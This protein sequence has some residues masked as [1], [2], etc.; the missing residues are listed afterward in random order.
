MS[1]DLNVIDD[2]VLEST[3]ETAVENISDDMNPADVASTIV[4]GATGTPIKYAPQLPPVKGHYDLYCLVLRWLDNPGPPISNASGATHQAAAIYK[5]LSSGQLIYNVI[6]KEVKVNL[7]HNA[8]NLNAAEHA[9]KAV[10][11]NPTGPHLYA[12]FN[13]HVQSFSHG[14]GDTAHLLGTLTR[15]VCHEM[16]H[17]HPTELGHSGK[18]DV[19][20]K[21]L[22]YDDGTSFMGRFASNKIT[23][24]QL[25]LLGWLPENK[26]AQYDIG[27][28]STD[29][30]VQNLFGG[31]ITNAVKVVLIP[32]DIGRPIYLS[33]PQVNGKALLA[34]HL[35]AARGS[36]RVAVFANKATYA[37]LTFQKIADGTGFVTVRVSST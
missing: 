21:L 6:V 20:G 15:D 26:V 31:D 12:I 32:R 7:H 13:N 36:Q 29:F 30:N 22:P 1:D 17:C 11:G 16:G 8:K 10:V 24:A 34:I 23:G 25:Y 19:H 18:Y 3:P 27:D 37:G 9:A 5:E 2:I 28:A 33:M 35:S 14:S 4:G